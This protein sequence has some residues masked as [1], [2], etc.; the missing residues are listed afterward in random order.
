MGGQLNN[1]YFP[2]WPKGQ[3]FLRALLLFAS[4]LCLCWMCMQI[5]KLWA[6]LTLLLSLQPQ[7]SNLIHQSC[8]SA[9]HVI[10]WLSVRSPIGLRVPIW[11]EW[12]IYASLLHCPFQ[13]FLFAVTSKNLLSKDSGAEA[14]TLARM[15]ES[16]IAYL[17]VKYL[18]FVLRKSFTELVTFL[19]C[20]DAL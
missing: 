11:N 12:W 20:F 8:A 15:K 3:P 6:F 17:P 14:W 18:Q 7:M 2:V 16:G 10:F 19:G 1:Q 9:I 4:L 5:M 13:L